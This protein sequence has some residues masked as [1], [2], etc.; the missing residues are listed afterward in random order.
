[1]QTIIKAE[2]LTKEYYNM[3]ALNNINMEV[4]TGKIVGLLG[5]NGSGKTTLLKII[6]GLTRYTSGRLLID[7]EEPGIYTKSIVSFLPDENHLYNWMTIKEIVAF[8]KDFYKDFD[9]KKAEELISFMELKENN[10]I[11]SLSKGTKRKL[12]ISL[13][14]SRK[15]KAYIMDEPFA[16]I[17]PSGKRK[18]VDMMLENFSEDSVILISTQL[19][20][21]TEKLY[22]EISYI[23]N[24][25]IKS[26]QMAEILRKEKGKS[27]G[28]IYKEGLLWLANS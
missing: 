14:L 11:S 8:F 3:T 27:V 10:I 6:A 17:D 26:T 2:N 16:G 23:E 13:V 20:S 19:I 22:D 24:G 28:D 9:A 4:K 18:I 25:S 7:G 12:A 5:P 15:A 1:M 21:E